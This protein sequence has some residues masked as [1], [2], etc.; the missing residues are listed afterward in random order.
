VESVPEQLREK[1]PAMGADFEKRIA[2]KI[3]QFDA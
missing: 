3:E 2:E 1:V